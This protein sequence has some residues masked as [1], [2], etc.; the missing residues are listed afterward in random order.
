MPEAM[1]KI[2]ALDFVLQ[3]FVGRFGCSAEGCCRQDETHEALKSLA[4]DG[5]SHIDCPGC[6]EL[7]VV[8]QK[9]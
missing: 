3:Q 2:E 4:P 9:R 8:A 5:L 7:L 6:H 1:N